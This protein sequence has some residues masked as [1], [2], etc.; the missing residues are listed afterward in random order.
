MMT[1]CLI[2]QVLLPAWHIPDPAGDPLGDPLEQ[3]MKKVPVASRTAVSPRTA[4]LGRLVKRARLFNSFFPSCKRDW[5]AAP[6]LTN[7][8]GSSLGSISLA[9]FMS[10]LSELSRGD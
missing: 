6:A 3:L 8:G 4:A 7:R 10:G 5:A 2:G 9:C 1:M